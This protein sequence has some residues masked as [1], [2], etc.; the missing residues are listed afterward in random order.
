VTGASGRMSNRAQPEQ[1]QTVLAYEAPFLIEKLLKDRVVESAEEGTAIF[2]EVKKYIMLTTS[3]DVNWQMYSLRV[4]EVW[5]QFILFT[6][7]Y[8]DF[9]E[10]FFGGYVGHRPSNAPRSETTEPAVAS[11]FSG[12]KN[13]Y[14]EVFGAPIPAIW[15]DEKSVTTR[16]RVFNDSVGKWSVR[17]EFGMANL[18]DANGDILLSVDDLA[19]NALMFV[20]QTGV[21]YV[22]EISGDLT[23]DE[24]VALIATLVEN[25]LLRVG[26]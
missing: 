3:D 25:K 21:F 24:K 13:R 20:A 2:D 17:N 23:D 15:F 7:E 1:F 10:R 4:D 22:R 19:G 5:H 12:F 26:S 18:L 6:D 9:C 11:S 16:R 8:I 14:E